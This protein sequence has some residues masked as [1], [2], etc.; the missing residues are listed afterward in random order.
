MWS[1][2]V[3]DKFAP[4][5]DLVADVLVT[6]AQLAGRWQLSDQTLRNHRA[7]DDGLPY[8]VLPSGAVRYRLSDV[9]GAELAGYR[10]GMSP[11]RVALELATLDVDAEVARRIVEHLRQIKGARQ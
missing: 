1:V 10:G 9:I 7:T 6:S 11:D 5:A 2:T 8:I 3:P 4:F